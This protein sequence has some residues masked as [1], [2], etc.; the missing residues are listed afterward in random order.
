MISMDP[1][2]W[3]LGKDKFKSL[4]RGEGQDYNATD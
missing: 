2:Q 4:D 3:L 1:P